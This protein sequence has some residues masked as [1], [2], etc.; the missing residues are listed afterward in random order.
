[1]EWGMMQT[2]QVREQQF[3]TPHIVHTKNSCSSGRRLSESM[4]SLML[5]LYPSIY[6]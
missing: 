3:S 4:T 1:M 5:F 2:E 6:I